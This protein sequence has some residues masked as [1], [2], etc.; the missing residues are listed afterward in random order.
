MKYSISLGSTGYTKHMTNSL[1]SY[2]GDGNFTLEILFEGVPVSYNFSKTGISTPPEYMSGQDWQILS[3]AF[4]EAVKEHIQF[5]LKDCP[6]KRTL[7]L[8]TKQFGLMKG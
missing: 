2:H 3:A 1:L 8:Q 5:A 6:N 7:D 4:D